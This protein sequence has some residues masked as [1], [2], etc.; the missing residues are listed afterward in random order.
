MLSTNTNLT[1]FCKTKRSQ[2]QPTPA[3]SQQ[4]PTPARSQQ[5]P[6]PAR[7]QQ[8]PPPA[9]SQPPPRSQ[10]APARSGA[11]SGA[12]SRARSGARSHP[13]TSGA[14]PFTAPRYATPS[15]SFAP[16]SHIG[17]MNWFSPSGNI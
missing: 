11:R 7:S 12:R 10:P 5:Q 13:S 14:R 16:R 8:Q 6:P 17:W 2:Q 9:R 3:R 1:P 15:T 4:Q